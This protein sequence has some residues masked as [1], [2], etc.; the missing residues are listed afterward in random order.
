[1]R[2][3]PPLEQ[4]LDDWKRQLAGA[5]QVLE[6]PT[7]RARPAVQTYRGGSRRAALPAAQADAVRALCRREGVTPFVVLLAAWAVLLGRHA[8]QEDVLVGT[9]AAGTVNTL[10]LR[11]RMEGSDREGNGIN[12][13]RELLAGVRSTVLDAY[14]HQD[15]PFARLV[16]ELVP[17]RDLSRPALVQVLFALIPGV[18]AKFDL[19]LSLGEE[20]DG[21]EGVLGYNADLFDGSTAERLLAR[22]AVLLE[23]AAGDPGMPVAELPLLLPAERQQM[24]VEWNDT[25]QTLPNTAPREASFPELFA[26]A[27]RAFPEEPAV[28][29]AAGEA[30]SY[31]RLDEASDRLARRLRALGVG[32]DQAVG[33]CMERAPELILG[34]VAILKAGGVYLPLNPAHPDERLDFQLDD[35]GAA[36][37]LVHAGTRERLEGRRRIEVDPEISLDEGQGGPLGPV[38]AESLAYII[39]TSGSTGIPKGVGVPHGAAMVHAATIVEDDALRPGERVVQ[40]SSPSFDVSL[41]QMLPTLISGAAVVLRGE[42]LASPAEMLPAFA[43]LGV[44]SANLPT[45]YW[46]QAVQEW[47]EESA[48]P[49]PLQ[50]RVQCVGGE[51][52]LPE[53][54]RRWMALAGPLGLGNVRLINGYGPTETVV[55]A[56]RYTVPGSIPPGASSVPIGRTLPFRAAY[57]IDGRG[58]LQPLGVLGELCL[59]GVMA[60]GYVNR[61]EL[62]A[63]KFV[64]NPWSGEPGARMYRTGD[65]VRQLPGGE[66]DYFGR[67][68]R[69]VKIR[70]FRIEPGEI[71]AVLAS[72]PA[73]KECAVVVREDRPGSRRLVGYVV[74]DRTD[75]TDR[76][77]RT[78]LKPALAAWLRERLPDY[79]IPAAF[80]VLDTLPLTANGKLDRRALPAPERGTSE[81]ESAAPSDPVEGLIAGIWAQV[82]EL[83]R[84]G[85]RDDFFALGG[86]SLLATQVI[87]RL[88]DLLQ[89]EVPFRTLFEHPTVAELARMI[90]EERRPS[91]LPP[92]DP[93]GFRATG[94]NPPLSFAQQ[95]LWFLDQ[96]APGSPAYNIPLAERL[97]GE[98]SAE[99]LARVFA[100]IVRRHEGVRTTFAAREGQPVQVIAPADAPPLPVVDLSGLVDREGRADREA[101]ALRIAVEEAYR[102]FDLATGPLLRLGLVR[103]G[104]LDHLLLITMHHIVSDG[105]S[106]GVL[107]REVGV[108]YAAFSQGRPSPLPELPVQSADFAVWQRS[109]FQGEVLERQLAYWKRQLDG[110]PQVL[111]LPTDRPRPAVQTY[112]GGARRAALTAARADAVRDLCRREGMTPFMVLLAALAVLLG[113]HAGQEDVLVGSPIAGRTRREIEDLIGLF[114]NTLVLRSR[115]EGSD[116]E[117]NGINSFRELLASV[118]STALDAYTHQDL[119]FERLVEELVPERDLSRT[120]LIQVLFVF[121]NTPGTDLAIPGVAATPVTFDADLAKLDLDLALWE[122]ADG[123]EGVLWHNADLFDGSTAERLLARFAV[124]LEAAAGNPGM[125][126]AELPLLL[127][128]ERQQMLAEWNDTPGAS[129]REASFPELFAEAARAFPEEPAV[130]SAQGEVWSYRRLDEASDRLARRLRGLGVRMDQAVGLCMERSP[131]LILGVV[132][133][134]KAGGVYLPLNP[135][136]P[137][138]RLD[139]QLDDTGAALVLVHAGTRERLEGRRRIEVDPQRSLDEGDG[140]SLGPV[141]AESLAYIIYTSGS[142]GISKGV[143]VPHGAAMV[144]SATIAEDDALRPGER[145]VQ[146]SSPSF[147]VSLEQ[148]L[149]TLISGAAVVLRGE[150]LA[151]PAE[152]LP[153]FARLGVTSANLP[154]AY[155]HQAVQE[156]PEESAPPLSL[157]L[158]VQCVGG[159]AMLPEA[160]RRWM[161][162]AGPLGLGNVRL[163]NG[164][165]P[166]ETVVT[167]TRH[168]VPG[169]IPPGASSVPIG[170]TLPHRAAYVVDG[171]GDLQPLGVL[172]ELCLGGVMARGYVN[173]PEL[174]AERFVPNPWSGEPGARMYRTGDLVRQLPG[175]ELDYFGRIDRQVKIRGFRIEPGEIEAVLASHPA[176]KECAVVVREDRPG[177]RQLV[178]YVVLNRTDRTDPTDP[179]DLKTTA[180]AAWLR[181]R[182]PD[183]M[184]P[185]VFVVL[186]VFPLTATGKLDRKALP[187]PE[188]GASD[189]EGPA[190]PA[191]PVEELIAGIWAQVLELDRVGLRD[192]FFALGGHS[193]LAT[194]VASRIR[195]VLGTE[196]PLRKLFEARTV[197]ELARA[198]R[199]A[200]QEG[201]AQ[202][203]PVARR[204]ADVLPPL[205]FG[206]QRFWFLERLDPGTPVF[207]IPVLYALRGPLEVGTLRRTLAEIVRRHEALRTTIATLPAGESFQ[208]VHP[209]AEPGL[210]VADLSALPAD[211]RESEAERAAERETRRGLSPERGPLVRFLLLRSRA[212]E[213]RFVATFHHLITDGLSMSVFER[214]LLALYEA[215]S[216]GRPSPLPELPVQYPDYA[217]WQRG[218]L[219][220]DRLV[221]QVAFWRRRLA[222]PLAALRLPTDHPRPEVPSPRG[223]EIQ[224]R[225]PRELA[226]AVREL[227][228]REGSTLYITLL[229]AFMALLHRATGQRDLVLG[230]PVSLRE[231]SNVEELIGMFINTL[232]IR[233]E[234]GSGASFRAL[235]AHVRERVLEAFDHRDVPFERLVEELQ[236]ERGPNDPPF[237]QLMFALLTTQERSLQAGDLELRPLALRADTAQF[238]LTL[239]MVDTGRELISEADYRTDLFDRGTIDRMLAAWQ[240]LLEAATAAPD[241]PLTELNIPVWTPEVRHPAVP[242]AAAPAAASA[243]QADAAREAQLSEMKSQ[244]SDAQKDRLKERLQRLKRGS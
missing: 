10:V 158:R 139:F 217:V 31:R 143:G 211:L 182:L 80:V 61:P 109:W 153:A 34:V 38:P 75:L 76:T 39:Y 201:T 132:A 140:G 127:P 239:Y 126:A 149:P 183:Y 241:L 216:A 52:M 6:L 54:A 237:F 79:M 16:E 221:D 11:I 59:G 128:A 4:Q 155:W 242:A 138:E 130:I 207:N 89:V 227:S 5:P 18:A 19:D 224:R 195:T 123:F 145:V 184:V 69:Q 32:P 154:T 47:P 55:T 71:E 83:D 144:H 13:F 27:A 66:L 164:Y 215:F 208:L 90:Q 35:T 25:P 198:V 43:R 171:H 148:M 62:T 165:G 191:D 48:P 70:G 41:E 103:L 190:A 131:E 28:I 162:L 24:L 93:G 226:D 169:S 214:E 173:R 15:V 33:L 114:V 210:P 8:G 220:G 100:E 134:L 225:L 199:A 118:R 96:L 192:D 152:M 2:E 203:P 209:P 122:G 168:T 23:A 46:H 104:E 14:A 94:E 222:P 174:T 218:T 22:F 186:D 243:V 64:P 161:A 170:R 102:P 187:A 204:G 29:S 81:E 236:P 95:R 44:T 206:Q 229:A 141:P 240:A 3:C 213:H 112:R 230:T 51:A 53:A 99:L 45:A 106:V 86:H 136:H 151:S 233:A 7:D 189:A 107:L 232:V 228:R 60:R 147:D 142:T 159:E 172:G 42:D 160:A 200:R 146:F 115:M 196:L 234:V 101:E 67:I 26:A 202:A 116:R 113:R 56:T 57:V 9:P 179:S 219:A 177:S 110:A 111:E 197:A 150:D 133:I 73:V 125:P 124:L 176:V 37:V 178:G 223:S 91:T 105:W 194:Q 244:L 180:L 137:D 98:L 88:R 30:W 117:G 50:L 49:L 135:A 163:I 185:A 78:D 36:L 166:T 21:F 205:S 156:W 12:S 40:F 1:M 167:A 68:D 129:P 212:E 188:R 20:A 175:G 77:D 193:L 120:A 87:S 82:L 121:Q 108:L 231:R 72:H 58:D 119:P 235:L 85:L 97:R 157:R 92:L 74:L 84:V 238:E 181:G 17:E 63:E 65:L